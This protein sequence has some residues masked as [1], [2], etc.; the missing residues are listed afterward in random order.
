[1]IMVF[2]IFVF[3]LILFFILLSAKYKNP[4]TLRYIFGKKG[5]GKSTL[6]IKWMIKDIKHNWHVYT[7]MPDVNIKGVHFFNTN[8]LAKFAP[9]P[10]SAIYLDEVTIIHR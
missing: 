3:L 7:D 8:D 2:F 9:P 6:M 5:A 1:M 4:Y 10:G